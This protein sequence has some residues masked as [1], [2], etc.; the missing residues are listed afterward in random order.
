MT[1]WTIAVADPVAMSRL[2]V[3][4]L[5][6]A[7]ERFCPVECGASEALETAVSTLRPTV[8][9]VDA[10]LP[11]KGG[12]WAV[13]HL[14]N[15]SDCRTILLE[16]TVTRTGVL[17]ALAAGASGI[18]TRDIS[19]PALLRALA[20]ACRGEALL[21]RQVATWVVDA[22]RGA[23]LEPERRRPPGLERLS[24]RERQVLRLVALGYQ[25]REIA[26]ALRVSEFTVKRHVQ[27]ILGK[28]DHPSREMAGAAYLYHL[29]FDATAAVHRQPSM[30]RGVVKGGADV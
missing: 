20:A 22:I 29:G 3:V 1:A 6:E 12:L 16:T 2:G 18:L 14:A 27:N 30:G 23:A 19:E 13:A 9:L 4:C 21:G 28:L 25:N 5:L 10:A 26:D 7:D 17:T 15:V 11:P 24:I 8:A